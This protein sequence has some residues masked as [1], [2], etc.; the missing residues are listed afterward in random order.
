MNVVRSN[1]CLK[2]G[3]FKLYDN[4]TCTFRQE[5]LSWDCLENSGLRT[6]PFININNKYVLSHVFPAY[7][8][9]GKSDS[10]IPSVIRM[11]GGTIWTSERTIFLLP[12][13]KRPGI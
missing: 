2:T 5:W 10:R 4:F 8:M 11:K 7:F 12:P 13:L 3:G 9:M 1:L 6:S